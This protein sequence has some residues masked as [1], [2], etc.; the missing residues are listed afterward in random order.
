[1][2]ESDDYGSDDGA[3]L[4]VSRTIRHSSS[5]GLDL[6]YTVSNSFDFFVNTKAI[7]SDFN[8]SIR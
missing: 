6:G 4:D 7:R 1:M 3:S 2:G 5:M 8:T